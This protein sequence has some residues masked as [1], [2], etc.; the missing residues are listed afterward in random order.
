MC[1]PSALYA[2]LHSARGLPSQQA[3]LSGNI[4][5]QATEFCHSGRNAMVF[6]NFLAL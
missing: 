2:I 3:A 6:V 1:V 4:E 5:S